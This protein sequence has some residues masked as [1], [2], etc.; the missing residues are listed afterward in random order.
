[1]Q[2]GLW[3][4]CSRSAQWRVFPVLPLVFWRLAYF[5]S[6]PSHRVRAAFWAISFVF[7]YD[8]SAP[9]K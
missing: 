7:G 2:D 5:F 1:M 9:P 8:E 3:N 4:S 6:R